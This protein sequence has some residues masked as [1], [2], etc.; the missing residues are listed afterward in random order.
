ML[1]LDSINQLCLKTCWCLFST[2][3]ISPCT[4]ITRWAVTHHWAGRIQSSPLTFPLPAAC[5]F[6][7]LFLQS[8]PQVGKGLMGCSPKNIPW[9]SC[10]MPWIQILTPLFKLWWRGGAAARWMK[11]K[12][13]ESCLHGLFFPVSPLPAQWRGPVP[14]EERSQEDKYSRQWLERSVPMS[15]SGQGMTTCWL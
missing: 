13:L 5:A 6:S 12:T 2:L 1:C 9:A 11:H 15:Y 7:T 14:P 8:L 4:A 3:S 10:S